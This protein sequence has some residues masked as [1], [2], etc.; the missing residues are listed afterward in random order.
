MIMASFGPHSAIPG[1]DHRNH[2]SGGCFSHGTG[3]SAPSERSLARHQFVTA[4]WA[5]VSLRDGPVTGYRCAAARSLIRPNGP[6]CVRRV[7][8]RGS[9]GAGGRR[10]RRRRPR[11]RRPGQAPGRPRGGQAGHG[12]PGGRAAVHD[13]VEPGL[14]LGTAAVRC[15]GG[16]RAEQRG[17][18]GPRHRPASGAATAS[19]GAYSPAAVSTA[20]PQA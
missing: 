17:Q 7:P 3:G 5:G 9:G 15:R 8:S 10:R 20:S 1:H 14:G 12:G 6:W 16:R 18:G 19:S 11:S 13:R 2:P 4:R